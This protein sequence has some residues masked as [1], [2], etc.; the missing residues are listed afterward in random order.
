MKV[1]ARTVYC[2]VL[3]I[4]LVGFTKLM[5]AQSPDQ[6]QN[7]FAGSN[8]FDSCDSSAL[9]QADKS[10]VANARHQQNISD[11]ENSW[12]SRS[13]S[14]LSTPELIQVDL[15]QVDLAVQVVCCHDHKLCLIT[16][17]PTI[18]N[19]AAGSGLSTIAHLLRVH[20]INPGDENAARPFSS[21][22]FCIDQ[23]GTAYA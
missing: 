20:R 1:T 16:G 15:I 6:Q 5:W 8:G 9:T 22:M 12:T 11:C 21:E 18:V 14:T 2:S 10:T 4:S 23:T 19:I 3:M 13:R 7:V 17:I